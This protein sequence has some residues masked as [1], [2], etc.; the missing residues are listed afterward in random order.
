MVATGYPLV[1]LHKTKDLVGTESFSRIVPV[2][3]RDANGAAAFARISRS[4]RGCLPKLAPQASQFLALGS[5]PPVVATAIIPIRLH[6]PVL[7]HLH[8]GPELQGQLFGPATGSDELHSAQWHHA[9]AML[10]VPAIVLHSG[11]NEAEDEHPDRHRQAE[12]RA[13]ARRGARFS[14]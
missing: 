8:R 14:L 11:V 1:G 5:G 12:E 9:P 4:R 7:D 10:C 3:L 13:S 6:E 2:F